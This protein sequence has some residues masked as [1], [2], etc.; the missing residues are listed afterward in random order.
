MLIFFKKKIEL[1]NEWIKQLQKA[2]QEYKEKKSLLVHVFNPGKQTKI[3][4][5]RKFSHLYSF[6][7]I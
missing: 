5:K 6:I 2:V 4:K 1:R 7:I 3:K